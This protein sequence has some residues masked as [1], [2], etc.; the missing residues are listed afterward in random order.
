MKVYKDLHTHSKY[1]KLNHGKNTIEELV[2]VAIAKGLKTIA[3]TDHAPG[4]PFGVW[5]HK[6][7]KRKAEIE[8]LRKKY[9]EIEILC[10]L[11]T[12]LISKSGKIDINDKER[13]DLDICL[14]GFHKAGSGN[15]WHLLN[16]VLWKTLFGKHQVKSNTIAYINAIN[17]NKIDIVTHLQQYI[18][19][20]CKAVAEAAARRGTL[21]EINN[22]H[23]QWTE[24]DIK[25]M[26][27]TDCKFVIDSD[28]HRKNA[29]GEFSIAL[30]FVKKYNIPLERIVNAKED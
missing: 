29:V 20:D 2:Q 13:A 8:A 28:A 4:H 10:G 18:K 23:L 12:N 11:E 27:E 5:R 16:F 22:R 14:M 19:V 6:L 30:D 15:L 7:K 1:S 17:N 26:L 24:Q 21:I 3:I 25:G 9:P